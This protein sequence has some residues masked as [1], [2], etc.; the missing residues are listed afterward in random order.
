VSGPPED[1]MLDEQ[2]LTPHANPTHAEQGGGAS[3]R[4][5]DEAPHSPGL[6]LEALQRQ[7]SSVTSEVGE[8][9]RLVRDGA[10]HAVDHAVDRAGDMG[11]DT[12]ERAR[13]IEREAVEWIKERPL[14]AALIS[15]GVGALVWSLV[16]RS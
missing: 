7:F 2:I 9:A 1:N 13:D 11:Q 5:R 8:L 16:K 6:T 3:A 12:T 4:T 14:Q 10:R 15:M